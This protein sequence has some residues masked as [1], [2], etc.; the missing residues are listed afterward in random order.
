MNFYTVCGSFSTNYY[1]KSCEVGGVFSTNYYHKTCPGFSHLCPLYNLRNLFTWPLVSSR[2]TPKGQLISK[3][4]FGVFNFSKKR[5]KTIRPDKYIVK[6][7]FFR[8]KKNISLRYFHLFV[9]TT[10]EMTQN[11][12]LTHSLR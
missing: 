3:G 4:L 10:F 11:S 7:I 6:S 8:S 9:C 2:W 12:L 5:T 1:Y